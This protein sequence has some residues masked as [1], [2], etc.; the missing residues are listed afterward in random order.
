ML[1]ST[2]LNDYIE[3]CSDNLVWAFLVS[4]L[5]IFISKWKIRGNF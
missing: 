1:N 3:E 2:S 5:M 4:E